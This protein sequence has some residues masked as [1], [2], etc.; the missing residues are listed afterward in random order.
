VTYNANGS[1]RN[2]LLVPALVTTISQFG[3]PVAV[4]DVNGDGAQDILVSVG[5]FVGMLDGK[6]LGLI[7]ATVPFPGNLGGIYVA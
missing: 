3:P 1:L 4:A 2:V 7:S 5:Q 6:T